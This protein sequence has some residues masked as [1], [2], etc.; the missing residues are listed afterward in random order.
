MFPY[1]LQV[2]ETPT[3][4]SSRG[5]ICP[6][7]YKKSQ[8][9]TVDEE[10]AQE[11]DA[12]EVSNGNYESM[13]MKNVLKEALNMAIEMDTMASKPL[14]TSSLKANV[15]SA[16]SKEHVDKEQVDEEQ[17]NKPVSETKKPAANFR[18]GPAKILKEAELEKAASRAKKDKGKKVS[19]SEKEQ[20]V[21]QAENNREEPSTEKPRQHTAKKVCV[22]LFIIRGI[23]SIRNNLSLIALN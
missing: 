8:Q 10:V 21:A 2:A 7:T 19:M 13:S 14:L 9:K 12:D 3:K 5:Q 17:V 11:A 23:A 4:I 22:I 1:S 15:K 20:T 18:R 16:H 6:K